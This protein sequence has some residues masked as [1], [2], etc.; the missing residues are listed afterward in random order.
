MSEAQVFIN[1]VVNN[2]ADTDQ[3]AMPQ[4]SFN[5]AVKLINVVKFLQNCMANSA[6]V[7]YAML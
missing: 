4:C 1:T 2:S 7:V 3:V 6:T 5:D